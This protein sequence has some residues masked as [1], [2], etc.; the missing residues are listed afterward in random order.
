MLGSIT[1]MAPHMGRFFVTGATGFI[2][3][4]VVEDLLRRGVDVT[5]LVRSPA[6]AT[7]LA[8][9]GARI[10]HGDLDDV[11]PWRDALRGCDVVIHLGGLVAA[12]RP[13]DLEAVNGRGSASLAAACARLDAPPTFVHVSSLA[14]LGPV[15]RD[16][17]PAVESYAPLPASA[18]G[19]SKLAGER[20]VAAVAAD[21]PVSIVRPGVVFGPHDTKLSQL[22]QMIDRL[23]LHLVMGFREPP[24]S[25]IHSSDLTTLLDRVVA[26][27][28]RLPGPTDA[29]TPGTGIYHAVDDRIHP[30]YG[31]L[32]RRI[33]RVLG[34]SLVVVPLPIAIAWPITVVV[35]GGWRL[36][37][38]ASIIGPDKLREATAANWAA[39]G[40][41]ARAGL[42]FTPAATLD[43]RLAETADWLRSRRLL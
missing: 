19:A 10:V 11:A 7:P 43:E 2:G 17:E 23:R 34:R 21:L 32:G 24:L 40:G 18:Y 14:A 1:G 8:D 12:L 13:G 22:F 25:L 33:A 6:R 16:A 20:G 9:A 39:S 42:G 30:T 3:R 35:E 28:E 15:G 41:K 38:Q 26:D 36:A 27:G 31:G 5:C 37:G 4:N 29:A